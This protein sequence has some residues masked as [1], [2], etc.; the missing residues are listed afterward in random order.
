MCHSLSSAWVT[1]ARGSQASFRE[2]GSEMRVQV[3][4]PGK[5][6]LLHRTQR[7]QYQ[8]SQNDLEGV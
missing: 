2:L 7:C 3:K 1:T 5:I 6:R 8:Q 4:H